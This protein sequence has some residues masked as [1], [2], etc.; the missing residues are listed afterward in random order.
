M[1]G[2][3]GGV[4]GSQPIS[5]AVR[6]AAEAQIDFGDLTPYL[7]FALTNCAIVPKAATNFCI[8][9]VSHLKGRPSL[10]TVHAAAILI[11]IGCIYPHHSSVASGQGFC[12]SCSLFCVL[13]FEQL[14]L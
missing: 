1:R 7:T 8:S 3:R 5:T 9:A 11:L 13:K 2:K 12:F 10:S 4:A 6:R 14:Q